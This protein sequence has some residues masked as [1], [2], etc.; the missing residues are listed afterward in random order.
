M[1]G[2]EVTLLDIEIKIAKYVAHE[3]IVNASQTT[4]HRGKMS[5]LDDLEMNHEGMMAEIAFCKLFNIYPDMNATPRRSKDDF[6]DCIL[7]G[8]RVDVKSTKYHKGKLL[9]TR[10]NHCN[11]DAFVLMTGGKGK[12][13]FRG[14]AKSSDVVSSKTL[15][16]LGYGLTYHMN[17]KDLK[18]YKTFF[19]I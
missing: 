8:L 9:V 6:G 19:G 7:H 1:I 15:I 11:S 2:T 12:Y 3:R 13:I 17:Q 4:Y 18:D 5:N 16:D 14:F 10:W